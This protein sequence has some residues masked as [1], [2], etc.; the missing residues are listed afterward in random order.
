MNG[1]EDRLFTF[2]LFRGPIVTLN[3]GSIQQNL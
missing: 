1:K 2:G 3:S